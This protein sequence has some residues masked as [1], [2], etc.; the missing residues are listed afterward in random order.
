MIMIYFLTLPWFVC[1]GHIFIMNSDDDVEPLAMT[2]AIMLWPL[3][4][5]ILAGV[6]LSNFF[7][8]RV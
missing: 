4:F 7:N 6:Q 5:A 3:T 1:L 2:L 8:K